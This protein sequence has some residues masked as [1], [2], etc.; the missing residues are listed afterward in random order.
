MGLVFTDRIST[1]T[2][3]LAV[4]TH[5]APSKGQPA[6][7][8]RIEKVLELNLRRLKRPVSRGSLRSSLLAFPGTGQRVQVLRRDVRC[9]ETMLHN[10]AI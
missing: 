2:D 10:S 8:D 7:A 9:S 6:I 5:Q 4:K 1:D 3:S